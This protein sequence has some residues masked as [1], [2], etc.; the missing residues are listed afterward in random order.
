[1]SKINDKQSENELF[2]NAQRLIYSPFGKKVK[3]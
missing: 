2:I 1:M 3:K